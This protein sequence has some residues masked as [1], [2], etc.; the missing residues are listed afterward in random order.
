VHAGDF[1]VGGS[2]GQSTVETNVFA[3]DTDVDFSG[4]DTG[5]K[6][7]GGYALGR[8]LTFEVALFDLGTIHDRV[9]GFD[10]RSDVYGA[11]AAVTAGAN[12]LKIANAY[13]KAGY[14]W[15]DVEARLDSDGPP[16]RFDDTG[17]DLMWGVG[18]RLNFGPVFVRAEFEVFELERADE[19][20][21]VSIGVAYRF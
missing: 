14:A 8:H 7:F 6:L 4:D 2:V 17:S 13:V 21:L 19:V 16:L 10:V 20:S 3:I 15:W 5:Y 18:L 11:D 9:F 1:F 12:F